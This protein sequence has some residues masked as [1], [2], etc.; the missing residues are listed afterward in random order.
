MPG[1]VER[2]ADGASNVLTRDQGTG[3][4]EREPPQLTPRSNRQSLFEHH[5]SPQLNGRPPV[6]DQV[7]TK[8]NLR[9]E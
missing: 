2:Q 5:V 9:V 1:S 4:L 7:A 3:V 6:L 8:L